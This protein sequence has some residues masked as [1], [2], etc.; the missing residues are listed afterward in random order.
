MNDKLI[1]YLKKQGYSVALVVPNTYT[2]V[3]RDYGRFIFLQWDTD[4]KYPSVK[5]F[6]CDDKST[7]FSRELIGY[8]YAGTIN[9]FINGF[10]KCYIT[11]YS[12]V[13]YYL[14]PVFKPFFRLMP[15]SQTKLTYTS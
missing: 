14:I 7:D 8:V 12:I 1:N 2:A 9:D 4:L 5:I 13:R 11:K 3:C 10:K 15:A 6:V